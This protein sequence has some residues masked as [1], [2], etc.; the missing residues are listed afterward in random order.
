MP[1][2]AK[3]EETI[4]AIT[5]RAERRADAGEGAEAFERRMRML[6]DA[7]QAANPE[8]E[9]SDVISGGGLELNGPEDSNGIQIMLFDEL[10]G[11]SVPYWHKGEKAYEVFREI[12]TYLRIIEEKAGDV[13]YDSQV[14]HVLDLD[15]DFDDVV[16]TYAPIS[17]DLSRMIAGTNVKKRRWWKFW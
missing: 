14:G 1:P 5:E 16:G 13:T 11:V 7:L 9:V 4:E 12:W 10:A 6:A 15:N 17:R 3:P 8:F 2:G